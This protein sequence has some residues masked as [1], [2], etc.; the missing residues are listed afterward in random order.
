M[1]QCVRV[2]QTDAEERSAVETGLWAP[3]ADEATA[4]RERRE[5]AIAEAAAVSRYD[6]RRLSATALAE[7]DAI[8]AESE[9]HL[10]E[11]PEQRRGPGRPRKD[12]S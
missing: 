3:T 4:M 7:R 5:Q 6:D 11:V 1:Q 10:V 12:G 2:V 9:A 8:D